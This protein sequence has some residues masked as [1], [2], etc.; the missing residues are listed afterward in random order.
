MLYELV[1]LG[2]HPFEGE[3]TTDLVRGIMNEDPPAPPPLY[4][5]DFINIATQ[6]L[7][8]DPTQRMTMSQFLASPLVANKVCAIP[9]NFKPKYH[10]EERFR[11]SQIRQL[12]HQL[13]RLHILKSG[14][15]HQNSRTNLYLGG[16]TP[17]F[18]GSACI[19]HLFNKFFCFCFFM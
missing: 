15:A 13:E 19:I 2:V 3:C 14:Q 8:K 1:L 10:I 9:N 11:R 16:G 18:V 12:S 17:W 5:S 4:S 7:L 6:L